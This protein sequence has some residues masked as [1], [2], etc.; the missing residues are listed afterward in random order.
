MKPAVPQPPAR[1]GLLERIAGQLIYPIRDLRSL[2]VTPRGKVV[3]VALISIL[4][5][6]FEGLGVAML[7]PILDY[8]QAKGDIAKLSAQSA[9]WRHI[10]SAFGWVGIEVNLFSLCATV[11]VLTV[12]RQV[13]FY[14][15][16]VRLTVLRHDVGRRMSMR[17]FRETL[18]SNASY[19]QRFG[20]GSFVYLLT[21]Q[22]QAANALINSYAALWSLFLTFA[23]YGAVILWAA[24]LTSLLAFVLLA[25]AVLSIS[26][27]VRVSRTISRRMVRAG[28]AW[29]HF[30]TE[31]HR[32]WRLV[33]LS[34]NIEYE[35]DGAKSFT[36]RIY[37]ISVRLA[38]VSGRIDL[39]MAPIITFAVLAGL[40]VAVVYFSVSVSLITLFVIIVMR[41]MPVA[42]NLAG[43]RQSIAV[44]TANLDR[45]MTAFRETEAAREHDERHAGVQRPVDPDRLRRRVVP[46]S[47]GQYSGAA[48]GDARNTGEPGHRDH[49]TFGRRQVD[50]RRFGAAADHADG[51]R[52]LRRRNAALRLHALLVATA[53]RLCV[54]GADRVRRFGVRQSSLSAAR[55]DPAGYRAG[56]PRRLRRRVHRGDAEGL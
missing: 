6:A 25:I 47:R 1:A 55:R 39:F 4:V 30:V 27:L 53:D 46:L 8:V 37:E 28:E 50:A 7:L 14:L 54:A 24:P 56:V 19:I 48:I 17:L 21:T 22:V 13:T 16:L 38:R 2:K 10:L 51:R 15:H 49:G 31:R 42:R 3:A 20:T 34:D 18:L 9:V 32:A 44:Q 36:D 40:Y 52:D 12:L 29:T 23:A 41:L 11:F 33:K 26:H 35:S 5:V 45:V 43:L